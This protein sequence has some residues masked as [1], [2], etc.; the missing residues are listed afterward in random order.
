M[1][2]EVLFVVVDDI[3]VWIQFII[4]ISKVFSEVTIQ[5]IFVKKND[6]SEN[7]RVFSGN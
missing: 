4:N 3:N 2:A 6:Y 5:S 7:Y 1:F